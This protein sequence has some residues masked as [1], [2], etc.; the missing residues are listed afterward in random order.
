VMGYCNSI[1]QRYPDA[2]TGR[3]AAEL[4]QELESSTIA[5]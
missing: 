2:P 5:E 1:S 4:A 3:A